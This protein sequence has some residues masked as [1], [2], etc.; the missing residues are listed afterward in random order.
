MKRL[1][2]LVAI[3]ASFAV[4]ANGYTLQVLPVNT[5]GCGAPI[6]GGWGWN[7]GAFDSSNNS[8]NAGT[9]TMVGSDP[10]PIDRV[11]AFASRW[12][13]IDLGADWA[14]WRIK[15]TWTLWRP[16][17]ATDTPRPGYQFGFYVAAD[18]MAG[19]GPFNDPQIAAPV[20]SK[21]NF[22]SAPSLPPSQFYLWT[23]DLDN[24]SDVADWV[25][26][27]ARYL[28]IQYTAS[29][30]GRDSASE[31]A[32]VGYLI[33]EPMTMSLLAIGGLGM[34]LRRRR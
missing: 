19:D 5:A 20:P 26:P 7:T 17:S 14:N 29:S 34:L 3:V 12:G 2:M 15:E 24:G 1:A 16:W 28:E 25:T 8:Y 9:G 11:P 31:F 33:P 10:G 23:K 22:D 32:F 30:L 6:G 4:I 13:Q 27:G 21:I 18:G